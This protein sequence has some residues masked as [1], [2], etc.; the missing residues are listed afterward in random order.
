MLPS[1]HPPLH[2][3]SKS[4]PPIIGI[5]KIMLLPHFLLSALLPEIQT[6]AR[7]KNL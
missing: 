6:G 7:V 4:S 5:A 3:H 2:F 1:L